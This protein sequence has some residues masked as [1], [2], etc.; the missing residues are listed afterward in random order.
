MSERQTLAGNPANLITWSLAN[1]HSL[2]HSL[3][4]CWTAF[5][6][7]SMLKSHS[8][9]LSLS[10]SLTL[11]HSVN[12]S[13]THSWHAEQL[14]FSCHSLTLS[15]SRSLTLSLSH[16]VCLDMLNNFC[17]HVYAQKSL[18]IVENVN[19]FFWTSSAAPPTP[20]SGSSLS[21]VRHSLRLKALRLDPDS[22]VAPP[23]PVTLEFI[24]LVPS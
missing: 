22:G 4:T 15:L 14:L 8:H 17:F 24:E 3:W 7:I 16:S 23:Y 9:I 6:F 11:S 18:F 21:A 19:D 12:L 13:F 5:V 10:L 20:E 2:I 1:V